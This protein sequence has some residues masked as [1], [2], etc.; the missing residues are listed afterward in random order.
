MLHVLRIPRTL[1]GREHVANVEMRRG[2]AEIVPKQHVHPSIVAALG[3]MI[4]L[5]ADKLKAHLP[6]ARRTFSQL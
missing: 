4:V 3:Q 5:D 6:R 2:L 1:V